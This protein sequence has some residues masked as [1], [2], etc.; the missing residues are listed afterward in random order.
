[1]S[2]PY[3]ICNFLIGHPVEL[4]CGAELRPDRRAHLQITTIR[5][6]RIRFSISKF[7]LEKAFVGIFIFFIYI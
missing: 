3:E 7:E 5:T 2:R 4:Q 6:P 1:M